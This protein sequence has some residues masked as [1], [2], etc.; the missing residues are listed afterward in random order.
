MYNSNR[1][2]ADHVNQTSSNVL[3]NFLVVLIIKS[4]FQ[5]DAI[6]L[7]ESSLLY[8]ETDSPRIPHTSLK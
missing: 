5:D 1:T 4:I 7:V 8:T 2:V 6:L 3:G